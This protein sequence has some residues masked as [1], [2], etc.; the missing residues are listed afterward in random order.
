MKFLFYIACF[1]CVSSL[2]ISLIP[3][4]QSLVELR[5]TDCD[6]WTNNPWECPPD[7]YETVAHSK[8]CDVSHHAALSDDDTLLTRAACQDRCEEDDA[9][10]FFL[11]KEDDCTCATFRFCGK[12]TAYDGGYIYRRDAIDETKT[13]E[14]DWYKGPGNDVFGPVNDK[15]CCNFNPG[16]KCS[17]NV[18]ILDT[19]C[20][21][22]DECT[23]D[24]AA[25]ALWGSE[26][27][28]KASCNHDATCKFYM[29]RS[30]PTSSGERKTC[31][32]FR[33]CKRKNRKDFG[34]A[35]TSCVYKKIW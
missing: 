33:T 1:V 23:G 25:H 6:P 31:A 18:L 15:Y 35:D 21:G 7:T 17:R 29:W 34:N 13:Y 3:E 14:T 12:A 5:T 27:K 2:P 26:Q 22:S 10:R 30:D 16:K 32:T 28:C 24:D 9:C 11:W 8:W 4:P 19:A 20:T